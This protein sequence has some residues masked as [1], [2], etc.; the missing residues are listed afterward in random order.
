M[1]S[2]KHVSSLLPSGNREM[3]VRFINIDASSLKK[4]LAELKAADLGEDFLKEVVFYDKEKT[5]IKEN[6]FARIRKTNKG[7]FMC[8]KHHQEASVMG[9]LELEFQVENFEKATLFLEEL[10]L[11]AYRAQEK[12][13]HSFILDTVVIDFDTWPTLPTYVELEGTS[14][15][16][17]RKVASILELDWSNVIFENAKTVIEKY[18]H[19]PVSTLR[20]FT[21][22]KQE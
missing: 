2:P 12:R 3:E 19:I 16:S 1:D 11:V 7:I 17:L 15:E 8:Y 10:G 4:K 18:Y 14:E 9:T 13:R 6:K 21:F 5:W 22:E 20:Y